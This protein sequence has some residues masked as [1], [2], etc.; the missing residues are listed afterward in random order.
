MAEPPAYV[1]FEEITSK[2]VFCHQI[3]DDVKNLGD[4]YTYNDITLHNFCLVSVGNVFMLT[5]DQYF[6]QKYYFCSYF[7]RICNKSWMIL[8]EFSVIWN[9][10]LAVRL[11]EHRSS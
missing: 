1:S 10:T 6:K 9:A 3:Y 2:C 7:H 8:R 4:K 11:S 5:K